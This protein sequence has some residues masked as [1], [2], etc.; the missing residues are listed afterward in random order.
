MAKDFV[1]NLSVQIIRNKPNTIAPIGTE[2]YPVS[3]LSIDE[4]SIIISGSSIERAGGLYRVRAS[5]TK[6]QIQQ[7]I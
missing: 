3:G 7:I 2:Q 1:Y 5:A 6:G 4:E